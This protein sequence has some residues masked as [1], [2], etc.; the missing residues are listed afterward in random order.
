MP[1]G[2]VPD[3]ERV[4]HVLFRNAFDPEEAWSGD[5]AGWL[6]GRPADGQELARQL[7]GRGHSQVATCRRQPDGT[8]RFIADPDFLRIS[9]VQIADVRATEAPSSGD[10]GAA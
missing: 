8:W 7:W 3:G 10:A 5:A 1:L 9:S 2:A 4:T 6:A